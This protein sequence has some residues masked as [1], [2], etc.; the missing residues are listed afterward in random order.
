MPAATAAANGTITIGRKKRRRTCQGLGCKSAMR[1]MIALCIPSGSSSSSA[2]A[3]AAQPV[4]YR[5]LDVELQFALFTR[6]EVCEH[7]SVVGGSELVMEI[8]DE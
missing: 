1:A 4:G 2:R 7:A 3:I 5:G 6:F 8:V